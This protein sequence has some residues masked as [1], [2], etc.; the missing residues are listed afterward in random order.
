MKVN[1]VLWQGAAKKMSVVNN[2]GPCCN[3][4][5]YTHVT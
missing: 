5:L 4:V 2:A 3:M 1:D